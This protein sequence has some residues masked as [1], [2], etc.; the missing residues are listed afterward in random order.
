MVLYEEG[1]EIRA[2]YHRYFIPFD[3]ITGAKMEKVIF[4][5]RI[6][7]ETGIAGLPDS[8]GLSKKQLSEV[9]AFIK[10]RIE[11][12]EKTAEDHKRGK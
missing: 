7:I 3:K 9:Y 1:I 8:L 12:M 11:S 2:F 10:N 6:K 5:W 4:F